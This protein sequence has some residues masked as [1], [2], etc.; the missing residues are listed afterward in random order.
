[1]KRISFLFTVLLCMLLPVSVY[2]V[3]EAGMFDADARLTVTG[4]APS[5]TADVLG[6]NFTIQ[7]ADNVKDGAVVYTNQI[8]PNKDGEFSLRIN[9]KDCPTGEYRIRVYQ[10]GEK[11][12]DVIRPYAEQDDNRTAIEGLNQ[13]AVSGV[14]D[15][16]E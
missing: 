14:K 1:M 5:G 11:L 4:T 9:L 2:A 13:A 16:E 7:D 3:A 10:K 8:K 6:N 15:V 12:I